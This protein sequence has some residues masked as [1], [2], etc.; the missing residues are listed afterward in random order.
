MLGEGVRLVGF[1]EARSHHFN[2]RRVDLYDFYTALEGPR[3]DDTYRQA[4]D[5]IA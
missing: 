5:D 4:A 3:L 1:E 2:H